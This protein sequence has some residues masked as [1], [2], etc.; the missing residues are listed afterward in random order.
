M[1]SI[2]LIGLGNA[3]GPLAERILAQGYAL[4]AFDIDS[5]ALDRIV[6]RGAQPAR[7]AG[8]AVANFTITL[9]PSSVEV[10]QAVLGENGLLSAAQPGATVIDLSGTDPDAPV[11]CKSAWPKNRCVLSAGQSMPTARRRW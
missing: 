4:T 9:L 10:R 7:H 2:G 8:A 5:Q 1:Q 3:G 11:S 6:Q